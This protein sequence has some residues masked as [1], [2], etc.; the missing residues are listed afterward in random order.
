M[1]MTL[2]HLILALL[3]LVIFVPIVV[4]LSPNVNEI[5]E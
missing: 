3:F 2:N 4:L 1:H 5:E